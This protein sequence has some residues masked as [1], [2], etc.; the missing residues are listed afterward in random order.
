MMV[1]GA[2]NQVQQSLRWFVENFG[3]IA[4][5]R[6]S[7]HRVVVF[8]EAVLTVDEYETRPET[9]SLVTGPRDELEFDKTS[10]TLMDGSVVIADATARIGPGERV[11]LT[12]ESGSGKS[13]LLRAVGGLWPWGA[14]KFI[15]QKRAR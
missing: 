15:F 9:I 3:R 13:T 7:L 4:D 5:W 14:A 8:R 2:F 6:S 11:L 1:V 10:V 12:G